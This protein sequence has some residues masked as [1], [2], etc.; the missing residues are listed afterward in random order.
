MTNA[1]MHRPVRIER[2]SVNSIVIDNEPQ[3]HNERLMVAAHVQLNPSGNTCIAR[4]TTLLPNIH[5][6]PY[7][8]SMLFAPCIELRY[9]K[10]LPLN[11]LDK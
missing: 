10:P 7:L 2:M 11:G 8:L 5:G 6:L 4:D 3:D 9:N 1:G